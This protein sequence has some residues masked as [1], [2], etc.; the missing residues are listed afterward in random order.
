M[1]TEQ[2]YQ[3]LKT[4]LLEDIIQKIMGCSSQFFENLAV[5]TIV[6]MGYG[7]SRKEAGKAIGQS[8]DNGAVLTVVPNILLVED[9]DDNNDLIKVYL[10]S[11]QVHLEVVKDG[12][13]A[14]DRFKQSHFDVILMDMQMP[15]MNGYDATVAIREYEQEEGRAPTPIIALT[16]D[17]VKSHIERSFKCGVTAHLTKPVAKKVLIET[18]NTHLSQQLY[19]KTT[20]KKSA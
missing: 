7:G 10:K 2:S 17:A 8:G 11:K 16:A 18:I 12:K 14:L 1:D 4:T 20:A 3:E 6:K 9:T 15:I 13:A 5:D 19:E